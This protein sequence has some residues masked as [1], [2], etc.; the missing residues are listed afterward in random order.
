MS[1]FRHLNWLFF[2]SPGPFPEPLTIPF[3]S[4]FFIHIHFLTTLEGLYVFLG[5]RFLYR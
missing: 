1:W 3:L 5:N 2:S 4:S